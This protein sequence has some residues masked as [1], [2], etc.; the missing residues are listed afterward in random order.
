MDPWAVPYGNSIKV[1]GRPMDV[2]M[3][4][5]MDIASNV[6]NRCNI[7]LSQERLLTLDINTAMLLAAAVVPTAGTAVYH[8]IQGLVLEHQ[9]P[10]IT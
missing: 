3:E 9:V 8:M 10:G 4:C 5:P 7:L 6:M 2:P 1:M